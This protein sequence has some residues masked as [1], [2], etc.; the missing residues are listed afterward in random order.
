MKAGMTDRPR[1]HV[2]G[3]ERTRREGAAA[4]PPRLSEADVCPHG[5]H[6]YCR[7]R[8]PRRGWTCDRPAFDEANVAR[9][10]AWIQVFCE[11]TPRVQPGRARGTYGS[12]GWKHVAES[13]LA[14]RFYV[15][16]GEFLLAAIRS[17][18]TVVQADGGPNA[19][20]NMRLRLAR[21][22]PL[23]AA[24]VFRI[25]GVGSDAALLAGAAWRI[26]GRHAVH[27]ALRAG[28]HTALRWCRDEATHQYL[29]S[30]GWRVSHGNRLTTPF[31]YLEAWPLARAART[32]LL[33]DD[34]CAAV[35]VPPLRF[36]ATRQGGVFD[37]GVR[38]WARG[39][40]A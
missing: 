2:R 25:A 29:A 33:W 28:L 30:R 10:L 16:N 17:G 18:Y 3:Q 27:G 22:G 36:D 5:V 34:R 23:T 9:C 21:P 19:T 38:T 1:P 32:Q 24:E 4:G 11:P 7:A 37:A 13:V 15:A 6:A 40:D 12:Y 26:E 39:G 8:H 14:P 31:R 20:L 35:G